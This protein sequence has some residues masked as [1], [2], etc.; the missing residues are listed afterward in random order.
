[1]NC[2]GI[3]VMGHGI[4]LAPCG[5]A[6]ERIETEADKLLIVTRPL[7]TGAACPI[8]GTMSARIHSRYRRLLTDLPS[9]GRRVLVTIGARR[10]RCIATDCP[11]RIFAER[12][13]TTVGGPFARRT[14]RLEGIVHHLGLA[15]GGRP[16]QSFARRLSLPVSNDTL[17]RVVRRRAG[18]TIMPPRVVGIDDFAWKRGHRYG[19]IICDLERRRII[20][21]LPDRDTATATAWLAE[22]ASITVIARDRGAG[23]RQAATAGRPEAVQVADRWHLM[24]N[25]SAAF[26]TAVQRSMTAIRKAVGMGIVDPTSL[27]AAECRQHAGW[28]RRE[29]QN[30]DILALAAQGV[31][32]KEIVRQTQNSRGLVRKVVR[33]ARHDI[34]RSRMSSLDPFLTLLETAWASGCHNGAALWRTM[35]AKGFTGAQRVVTEWATRKRKD[36]GTATRNSRPG[37]T[38][39]ARVIA[40]TMTTERDTLSK[41]VARTITMIGEAVPDLTTAR[42]LLDR[43]HRIIQHRQDKGLDDWITDAKPGLMASFASGIAQDCAAVKAALTEPW[44]NGQT[45]GQNTKLKLVKRQMYGRANLDLL[46]ARLIGAA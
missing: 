2:R 18:K 30:T 23:Y 1:M 46:R 12:L 25:A 15:L 35:N 38:P 3:V 6:I 9:Q 4:T 28:L 41:T 26:L 11:R 45:E 14:T 16:G 39:S 34:F 17:L 36:E 22:H 44:S 29:A 43:F 19:T 20:D 5:L 24:E 27:S 31:A 7:S 32:I 40:R 42:D 13:E 10:F 37:Q 8:C 33:G 21:I